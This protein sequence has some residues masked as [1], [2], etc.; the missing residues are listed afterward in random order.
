[1]RTVLSDTC[2]LGPHVSLTGVS[3]V[4]LTKLVEIL[5][6]SDKKNRPNLRGKTAKD[7]IDLLKQLH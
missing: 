5:H 6:H 7:L 1:M 2:H 3:E 4:T